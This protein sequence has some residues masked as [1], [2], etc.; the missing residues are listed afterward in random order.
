MPN[1]EYHFYPAWSPDSRWLVFASARVADG[2]PPPGGC[3]PVYGQNAARL[4][5]VEAVPGATP[6]ELTNATHA[7]LQNAN[8]PRFLPVL[9][10]PGARGGLAFISF[11]SRQAYGVLDD[12]KLHLWMAAV[13]LDDAAPGD[14]SYA[15]FWMP[16]QETGT[17][18]IGAIWTAVK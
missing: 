8:Q 14:P 10:R 11:D 13:R 12:R 6:V 5:L 3:L 17:M 7:P 15:P 18:S 16:F 1:T 4:R 2:P 9:L